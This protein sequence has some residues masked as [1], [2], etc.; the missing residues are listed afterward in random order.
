MRKC[1]PW[2]TVEFLALLRRAT[3]HVRDCRRIMV[4][5][6]IKATHVRYLPRSYSEHLISS[7]VA[8][9]KNASFLQHT[10]KGRVGYH[11]RKSA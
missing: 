5:V 9:V 1:P 10:R 8:A 11:S 6:N 3:N 2:R 7:S 4:R